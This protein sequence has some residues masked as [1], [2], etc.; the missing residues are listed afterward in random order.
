MWAWLLR[1]KTEVAQPNDEK[2]SPEVA[3]TCGTPVEASSSI[4]Y[5]AWAPGKH[6]LTLSPVEL[7]ASAINELPST[8][9]ERGKGSDTRR[10]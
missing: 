7:D 9:V 3:E 10:M 2:I 8:S 1:K 4:L 5:E 6:G